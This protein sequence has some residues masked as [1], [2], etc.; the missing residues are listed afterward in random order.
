MRNRTLNALMIGLAAAVVGIA[1]SQLDHSVASPRT[2]A[3]TEAA[4]IAVTVASS[5]S[6]TEPSEPAAQ[7][8]V[9][10]VAHISAT[11]LHLHYERADNLADLVHALEPAARAGNAQ[12]ARVIALA[13][14]ECS[15]AEMDPGWSAEFESFAS[16]LPSQEKAIALAHRD[17]AQH[18]CDSLV[19][20][21]DITLS[22]IGEWQQR[23]LAA[24]DPMAIAS[25]LVGHGEDLT[26]ADVADLLASFADAGDGEAL[27]VLAAAGI[28][29][30][31]DREASFVIGSPIDAHA[32]Q[33]IACNLGRDCSPNGRFMRNLCL[34]HGRCRGESYRDVTRRMLVT[35]DTYQQ[36][37]ARE[38]EIVEHLGRHAV[39]ELFP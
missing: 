13:F 28:P 5:S 31:P 38:R 23:A 34:Q 32:W 20:E 30:S 8:E 24:G 15:G 19:A 9:T 25:E 4:S 11:V 10:R 17:R 1:A 14:D 37:E 6:A 39:A 26:R 36:I 16:L 22:E 2:R 21:F 35:S 3:E 12:A 18:R 33:L 7:L 29:P 27:A